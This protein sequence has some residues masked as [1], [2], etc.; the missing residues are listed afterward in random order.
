MSQQAS[1]FQELIEEHKKMLFK[2]ANSYCRNRADQDDLVQEMV[3]Q[4]WR[5]FGRYDERLRFSTWMYRVA[6]NTAI[7]YWRKESRR[8]RGTLTDR[9]AVVRLATEPPEATSLQ[10]DLALLHEWIGQLNELDRAVILLYLDGNRYDTIAEILGISQTNVGTKI[11]RIKQKLRC[12]RVQ[13]EERNT[14]HGT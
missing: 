3:L 14:S 4:L 6:L 7:S 11:N 12:L 13:H 8:R 2:I 1:R 10:E 5:S 9:D